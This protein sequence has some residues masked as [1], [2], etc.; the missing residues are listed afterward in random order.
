M[1]IM[2]LPTSVT[3]RVGHLGRLRFVRG[4]YAYAGSACGPGGLKARLR[5]HRRA[6]KSKH[7]HVD[8]LRAYAQPTSVWYSV[9]LQR[10]ECS[11]AE[12]LS[13]L[14]GASMP[15]PRFGASDCRCAAHLFH[16]PTSP[17]KSDFASSVDVPVLEE[18]FDV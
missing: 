12:A 7:W 2:E 1:L 13:E 15:A 16:F 10:R 3:I 8:Y 17:A 4:W 6:A 5:R 18:V 14:S 9:G 11:W